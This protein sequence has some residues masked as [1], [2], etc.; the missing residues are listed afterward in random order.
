MDTNTDTDTNTDN[1]IIPL[2]RQVSSKIISQQNGEC[3]A[4]AATNIIYNYL[5]N[6][7]SKH[8]FF[9]GSSTNYTYDG[10]NNCDKLYLEMDRLYNCTTQQISLNSLILEDIC[11]PHEL[12]SLILYVFIYKLIIERFGCSGGSVIKSIDYIIT[13]LYN[14]NFVLSLVSN[15]YADPT[16][17]YKNVRDKN[18]ENTICG[19]KKEY[20]I[21][22]KSL[23]LENYS[24]LSSFMS[25]EKKNFDI[26]NPIFRSDFTKKYITK[27]MEN[28]YTVDK[29]LFFSF[30]EEKTKQN[31]YLSISVGGAYL[32]LVY[33]QHAISLVDNI[34]KNLTFN[35]YNNLFINFTEDFNNYINSN[36]GHAMIIVDTDYSDPENRKILLKNSWGKLNYGSGFFYVHEKDIDYLNSFHDFG[37]FHLYSLF[38]N[39]I[40]AS[41]F[42]IDMEINTICN[43]EVAFINEIKI[44][45]EISQQIVR[46][47]N[48]CKITDSVLTSNDYVNKD[49]LIGPSNTDIHITEE[50]L[51]LIFKLGSSYSLST[52]FTCY[53]ENTLKVT[54]L[55]DIFLEKIF[56]NEFYEKRYLLLLTFFK[57]LV[58]YNIPVNK[59]EMYY[60]FFWPKKFFTY[61]ISDKKY[62]QDKNYI[63]LYSTLVDRY[64]PQFNNGWFF[65]GKK[66]KHK[67][68]QKTKKIR[69]K[70]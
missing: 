66:T 52:I 53:K 13:K 48:I 70:K 34:N 21:L 31:F 2:N 50:Q 46:N 67:L 59:L 58:K 49:K 32:F 54:N 20:C 39:L 47:K 19:F 29:N 7:Y 45:D 26:Y 10:T 35:E 14:R 55:F 27:K 41:N 38:M 43:I 69:N 36:S 23:L 3:F 42:H 61:Y 24:K 9:L 16:I 65:G 11:R 30:I 18:F 5:K 57:N 56:L 51:N 40:R 68:K 63:Q 1:K 64:F 12:N 33:R 6:K 37:N 25:I 4:H 15:L 28:N 8:A 44:H 17:S 62:I 60:K 22:I